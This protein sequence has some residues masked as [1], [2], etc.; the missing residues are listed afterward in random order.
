MSEV[1][2][3]GSPGC[4][5]NKQSLGKYNS[6]FTFFIRGSHPHLFV[7]LKW[8]QKILWK[9]YTRTCICEYATTDGPSCFIK[10]GRRLSGPKLF[11]RNNV[12]CQG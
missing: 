9:G 8:D 3:I 12:L 10:D 2:L 6:K 11:V 4:L 7:F 1:D 5:N